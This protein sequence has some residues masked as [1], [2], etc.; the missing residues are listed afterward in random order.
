MSLDLSAVLITRNEERDLPACLD[1]LRGLASEIVVVD[2]HSTDRTVEIA[3]GFGA[4][5]EAR[6][7]DGYASQKQF[8][9]ERATKGWILSIDADERVTPALAEELRR[10]L[11]AAEAP[12][13][14]LSPARGAG[15]VNGFVIPF[16]VEFMGS[17]LRWGG[18]GSERH[19]RLVRQ[20]RG[21]FTGGGL[22]EGLLAPEPL[23][24]TAGCIRHIPYRDVDEYL[25][26][27]ARYTSL[28]ARK[29]WEAGRRASFAHHLLPFWELF[30]RLFLRL[31]VLDGFPGIVYAGLSC[32]H[33]WVKYVKLAE[34]G[35]RPDR[36]ADTA[37]E[38]ERP[39]SPENRHHD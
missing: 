3:R 25:E 9:L 33:T 20:G 30:V 5:V 29:R 39:S 23:G 18:L 17:V 37:T 19:L 12:P 10:L 26:K 15:A 36:P 38:E 13:T 1:S 11:P 28:A 34:L 31:G 35:R 16:E 22:H 6:T 8:A 4:Q 14:Q 27:L 7:F 21:R 32:F 2:N 24:R